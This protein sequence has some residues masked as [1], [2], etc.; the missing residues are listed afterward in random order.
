[1]QVPTRDDWR[2]A[3]WTAIDRCDNG[4]GHYS[5][6]PLSLTPWEP[7]AWNWPSL[8]HVK[9]PATPEVVLE[10]RLINDMKTIMTEVEFR[11]VIGHLAAVLNVQAHKLSHNWRCGRSFAVE[12][13]PAEEP[14][15]PERKSSSLPAARRNFKLTR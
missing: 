2:N 12:E 13:P 14:P 1:M 5:G 7:T 4:R 15:L 9:D 6:L 8:D 11:E 10:I 3:I